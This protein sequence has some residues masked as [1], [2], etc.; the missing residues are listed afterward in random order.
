MHIQNL[1][2]AG[3]VARIEQA[4]SKIPGVSNI[5]IN[6]QSNAVSFAYNDVDAIAQ[7]QEKLRKLGY[8]MVGSS[9]SLID[10]TAS[11]VSC[12]IGKMGITD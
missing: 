4:V 1:K 11:Y 2:C 10:K 5:D 12:M 6:I 9:N 7:V 8:P 3:C